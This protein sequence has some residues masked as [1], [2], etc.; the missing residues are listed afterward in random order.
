MIKQSYIKIGLVVL[1]LVTLL[2]ALGVLAHAEDPDNY[3][4]TV[5]YD[6]GC[7]TVYYS[8]DGGAPQA[9]TS[10]TPYK[11]PKSAV[12]VK[13]ELKLKRGYDLQTATGNKGDDYFELGLVYNYGMGFTADDTITVTSTPKT[14]QIVYLADP[15]KGTHHHEGY[16]PRQHTFGQTDTYVSIPTLDGYL[17]RG[18]IVLPTADT[19]PSTITDR[20]T[21]AA[22]LDYVVFPSGHTPDG[23]TIYLMPA[24]EAKKYPV[25]RVDVIYSGNPNS[26]ILSTLNQNGDRWDEQAGVRVTGASGAQTL[27]PGYYYDEETTLKGA[28]MVK[29]YEDGASDKNIIYRYYRPYEYVLDYRSSFGG[30]LSFPSGVTQPGKHVF[31]AET[32][33]P[34]PILTG[35]NFAGWI[36]EVFDKEGKAIE[37]PA[38]ALRLDAGNGQLILPADVAELA[39]EE[40]L[41]ADGKTVP[42]TIRLTATWKAKTFNIAYDWN[43]ADADSVKFDSSKY[44]VYTYDTDLVIADPIRKGYT[45]VGWLLTSGEQVGVEIKSVD[46]TTT[47]PA[48]TY[49]DNVRLVAQ[50]LPNNYT[51]TVNGNGADA[52]KTFTDQFTVTFDAAMKLPDGFVFPVRTGYTFAGFSLDKEG[53]QMYTDANGVPLSSY[54]AWT[55]DADTVLYAQWTINQYRVTVNVENAEVSIIVNGQTYTYD[56]EQP[57]LFDYATAVKVVVT[58]TGDHKLVKWGNDPITHTAS[59]EYSFVLGAEDAVLSGVVLRVIN[60]PTFKIDYLNELIVTADGTIPDGRYR[61]TCGAETLE[62]VVADGKIRING[63]EQLTKIAIPEGYFGQT[64][65]I[66]TYG[67]DGVTA[68]SDVQSINIA[69]RPAAPEA[70]NGKE[71][72]SVYQHEDTAIVVQMKDGV[73]INLYEFACSES[74]NGSGLI[75]KSASELTN[76]ETPANGVM[77]NNLKPGAEYYVYI[78]E[79]A[80][81]DSHPHG[82]EICIKQETRSQETLEAKKRELMALLKDTDGDVTR[83]LIEKALEEA[84]ALQRPAPDF[85]TN[86]EA[87]YNRVVAEI[88]FTRE[89]DARLSELKALHDSLINSGAFNTEGMNTLNTLYGIAKDSIESA[90][91]SEQVQK[92]YDKAV[93]EMKAVLISYLVYGDLELTTHAGLPQGTKLFG[94]TIENIERLMN[95]VDTAIGVGNVA[96]GGSSMTLAEALE[97]LRSLEVKAAYQM[98]LTNSANAL[99]NEFNG[100]YEIRVL[101]PTELRHV[102]GLQVAYYDEKTGVLEVLDTQKDGNC[103]VFFA[104]R[105]ADF[106]ILGDPTVNLTGFIIALGLILACQL[107]AI[108]ILLARRAKYAKQVR[109]Y[110]VA[111]PMLLTIRFLPQNGMMLVLVLGGLV[112]LFQIILMYL[113][114]SSEVI[115]R[116]RH[117][118]RSYAQP[119]ESVPVMANSDEEPLES[120][121]FDEETSQAIAVFETEESDGIENSFEETEAIEQEVEADEIFDETEIDG[122]EGE[123]N[124]DGEAELSLDDDAETDY[125]DFIE[126]AAN[127]RYSLPDEDEEMFVDTETGEI[128]SASD[129]AQAEAEGVQFTYD[130]GEDDESVEQIEPA[131]GS[132]A[133]EQGVSWQYDDAAVSA[134]LTEDDEPLFTDESDTEEIPLPEDADAP[135]EATEEIADEAVAEAAEAAEATEADGQEDAPLFYEEPDA[136]GDIAPAPDGYIYSSD[137]EDEKNKQYND[138]EA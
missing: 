133:A 111:L 47:L 16:K 59:Y 83:A 112:V 38:S 27:Y 108:I 88:V 18:W 22:G 75:W 118:S 43:G 124:P 134:E 91:A 34:D 105:I 74:N 116:R 25:Y 46:G 84:N 94:S 1:L 119:E 120:E 21:P 33:I 114:L 100:K 138:Y 32:K 37:V 31:N 17:F 81:A 76:D 72:E 65:G 68:D 132:E 49:L 115:Y 12:N 11:V 107:I 137:A 44:A 3:Q 78:R 85:Y 58:T 97:A 98:K 128:Y 96:M 13:L 73:D 110:S 6:E 90:T 9:M 101:L 82:R 63:G 126:P 130:D 79:K 86:L 136:R 64:I 93:V 48:K 36:V 35:Y 71:I 14:Y 10:G 30:A 102:S 5:N 77:F 125:D 23:D 29:P 4:L 52:D 57:L 99:F 51:V 70:N 24:W 89:Q 109:R 123:I 122:E 40:Y 56:P 7:E 20:L 61:I 104:D 62:I 117:G 2:A 127:P 131:N 26:P 55:I 42:R 103:L 45:F 106:V 69:A 15:D 53:T 39:S 8:Y 67:S 54:P 28:I 19:D 50:W 135:A 80:V 60:A 66:M 95:S 87:I 113:L 92:A 129:I 41:D 121:S